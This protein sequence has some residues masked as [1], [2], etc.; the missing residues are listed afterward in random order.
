MGHALNESNTPCIQDLS[1]MVWGGGKTK[2]LWNVKN[3]IAGIVDLRRKSNIEML[4]Y[5][6]LNASIDWILPYTEP[7][8]I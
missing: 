7:A 3:F 6:Q 4:L 1:K 8:A 5:F 2:L